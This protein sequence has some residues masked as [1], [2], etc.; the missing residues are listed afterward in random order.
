LPRN[1]TQHHALPD[2]LVTAEILSQMLLVQT[3]YELL[4]LTETPVLLTGYA[5]GKHKDKLWSEVPPDYLAGLLST[6]AVNAQCRA[7]GLPARCPTYDED[8]LFTA[9]TYLE[10]ARCVDP[11]PY[12]FVLCGM[13]PYQG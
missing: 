8:T 7:A 2:A 1:V 10:R 6:P 4:E 12:A 9:R 3:V 11:Q 5:F 13:R